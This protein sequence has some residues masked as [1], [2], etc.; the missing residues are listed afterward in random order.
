MKGKKRSGLLIMFYFLVSLQFVFAQERQVRFSRLTDKQGLSQNDVNTVFQDQTGFIWLGTNGGLNRFDGHSF[1]QYEPVKNTRLPFLGSAISQICEDKEG[2]LWIGTNG[3]GVNRYNRKT[4][5]FTSFRFDRNDSTSISNNFVVAVFVDSKNILW[6]STRNGIN[7][8]DLNLLEN[9]KLE[10]TH[11]RTGNSGN[12]IQSIMEDY[13][14]SIWFSASSSGISKIV[15]RSAEKFVS[16]HY[17]LFVKDKA[18]KRY[19]LVRR[20]LLDPYGNMLVVGNNGMFLFDPIKKE[21]KQWAEGRFTTVKYDSV[22]ANLWVGSEDGLFLYRYKGKDPIPYFKGH[23]VNNY[24]DPL[25]ISNNQVVSLF[26]DRTRNVWVGTKKGVNVISGEEKKFRFFSKNQ[27]SH[28]LNHNSVRAIVEDSNGDVWIGTRGG[29]LDKLV[30]KASGKTPYDSFLHIESIEDKFDLPN[31]NVVALKETELQGEKVLLLGFERGGLYK[32][33]LD[34]NNKTN[35][36]KFEKIKGI[37]KYSPILTISTD[38]YGN[39]W[40]GTYSDGLYKIPKDGSDST[41]FKNDPNDPTSISNNII[42]SIHE[43]KRGF[44][45]VGTANG[46]NVVSKTNI[47]NDTYFFE[48]YFND[49]QDEHIG[50]LSHDYILPIYEHKDGSLWFGTFGGGLNKM[51]IDTASGRVHFKKFKKESGMTGNII[52]SIISDDF[53]KIW[54]TTNEGLNSLNPMTESL[55]SYGVEDGL[56]GKEFGELA[57]CKRKNGDILLGSMNGVVYFSA[58]K[59][60]TGL[61]PVKASISNLFLLNEQVKVGHEYNNEVVLRELLTVSKEINLNYKNKNFELEFIALDYTSLSMGNSISSKIKYAYM[62][63]GFDQDWTYTTPHQRRAKYTNVP[64][65]KYTFLVKSCNSAGIWNTSPTTLRITI[66]PPYWQKWWFRLLV[67]CFLIL[68][69]VLFVLNRQRQREELEKLVKSRTKQLEKERDRAEKAAKVKSDFLSV[70]SHEIRT[71]LNAVVSIAHLLIEEN[72]DKRLDDDLK[73]LKYSSNGLMT[74]INDILDLNQLESGKTQLVSKAFVFREVMDKIASIHELEAKRKGLL[75]IN[76]HD[77][78]I[79]QHV[80]GDPGSL[81]QVLSNLIGNAIKFT[82]SGSITL[83]SR[84]VDITEKM[85]SIEFSVVDTGIGV[86]LEKQ[87]VIFEMFSQANSDRDR[88]FGGVGLGLFIS[89][90]LVKM[91]GGDLHVKSEDGMGACFSFALSFHVPDNIEQL[92]AEPQALPVTKPLAGIKALMVDDNDINRKVLKKFLDKWDV[93]CT[94]AINGLQALEKVGS[95]EFDIIL[96]DIHMPDMDGYTAA[97]E[98]RKNPKEDINTIPIIAI[99]AD[100]SNEVAF[101]TESAGMNDIISKPFDP[102]NLMEKLR[103]LTNR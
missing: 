47:D 91:M 43:D 78:N 31:K 48:K 86:P 65:G 75:F 85:I 45:W 11:Y 102:D 68:V 94:E 81:R 93:D 30:K 74:L 20:I 23:Y 22:T 92:S 32:I 100:V 39:I 6:V 63:D 58:K 18:I 67:G 26:I 17:P 4:G 1:S 40:V 83:S 36:Y 14:G 66:S 71:P 21:Y 64:P 25:S 5:E 77:E 98:I 41:I 37:N 24:L 97:K 9:N 34:P 101:N 44:L 42:R 3:G 27:E 33:R 19:T 13:E 72:K 2:N 29:G 59:E 10:F 38:S 12:R 60:T 56:P 28:S 99:S 69:L 15:S 53:D 51:L 61:L 82:F 49:K 46:L 35:Q 55:R 90:S 96:M 79:P 95:E 54:I 52:K 87:Q 16:E 89:T 84:L 73:I 80:S 7:K 76:N 57:S 50:S 70:M 88:K 103:R 62:L 8:A